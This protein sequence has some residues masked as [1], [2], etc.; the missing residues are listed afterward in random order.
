MS[1]RI[2]DAGGTLTDLGTLGFAMSGRVGWLD[3]IRYTPT[4]I[5]VPGSY[6]WQLTGDDPTASRRQI[7]VEGAFTGLDRATVW[8]NMDSAKAVISGTYDL[9]EFS[10]EDQPQ[11]FARGFASIQ[12]REIAP[13]LSDRG[14]G[15]WGIFATIEFNCPDPNI[16]DTVISNPVYTLPAI[17]D[18]AATHPL[19]P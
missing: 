14:G 4:L 13:V 5:E 8:A 17:G 16:Y 19:G 2:G 12:F 10:F 7:F 15:R 3:S 11:Y 9:R 18:A 1:V 6:V